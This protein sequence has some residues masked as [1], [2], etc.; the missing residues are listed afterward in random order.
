MQDKGD[1]LYFLF[2][3]SILSIL[4][5][6][7]NFLALIHVR[8]LFYAN[9]FIRI[10]PMGLNQV[11]REQGQAYITNFLEQAMQGGLIGHRTA[12]ERVTIIV[13][14]DG[15]ALKP[16]GPP[17]IKVSLEADFVNIRIRS[18]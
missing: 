4:G 3:Y 16:F 9:V 5:I 6:L 14:R 13:Q 8:D 15:H 1:L 7:L 17:V 12:E 10:G 2:N 18:W 11:D